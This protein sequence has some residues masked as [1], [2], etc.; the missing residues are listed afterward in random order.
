[1]AGGEYRRRVKAMAEEDVVGNA[2]R[3][4]AEVQGPG[5]REMAAKHE[6]VSEVR[7]VGVFWAI[8]LVANRTTK[9][10]LAASAIAQ[11][12][13]DLLDRGLLPFTVDNRI[14]VV[15]PANIDPSDA[16]HGLALIDA[17]LTALAH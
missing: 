13:R 3:I 14:H 1:M 6:L 8:E 15:P 9:A 2:G 7:G 12:R 17:A 4:G 16:Q 11:L 5:L 10:P